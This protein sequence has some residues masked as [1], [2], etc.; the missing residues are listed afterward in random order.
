MSNE[1]LDML[2]NKVFSTI[3]TIELMRLEINELKDERRLMEQ[4]VRDLI[5]RIEGVDNA[6]Q[7]ASITAASDTTS[8][9]ITS[10]DGANAL[11]QTG[12]DY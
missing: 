7:P 5:K 12:T 11:E 2:E 3:E 1:L 6:A 4:K 8:E 9:E 10:L